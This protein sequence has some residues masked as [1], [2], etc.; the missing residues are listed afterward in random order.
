MEIVRLGEDLHNKSGVITGAAAGIGRAAARLLAA[1]GCRTA[2]WDIDAV[3]LAQTA[4]EVKSAGGQEPLTEVV[5]IRDQARVLESTART[6]ERIGAPDFLV[7]C[8]GILSRTSFQEVTQE[9]F[10]RVWAVNVRGVFNCCR[11]VV[12]FMVQQ[13]KGSIVNV[14]SVAGRTT[15]IL[16]GVG[17]TTSKHAVVGLTRH[18]ARELAPLGVR[19]NALCPGATLT[20]MVLDNS[21]EQERSRLIAATPLRRWAEPEEQAMIIAFL[22]SDASSNMVGAAVDANGGVFMA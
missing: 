22:V 6:R 14:A 20:A 4:A 7:N 13:K 10:D 5:D 11:A 12:P 15:S 8:A 3:K 17:Y 18:L 2:L 9:E 1:H 19:V 16:G 21:E